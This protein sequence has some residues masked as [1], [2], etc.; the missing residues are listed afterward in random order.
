MKTS[1]CLKN[2]RVIGVIRGGLGKAHYR[3]RRPHPQLFFAPANLFLFTK[4][5]PIPAHNL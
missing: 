4:P 1:P 5:S 3:A 2:I